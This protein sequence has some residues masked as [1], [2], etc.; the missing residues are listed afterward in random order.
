MPDRDPT[1]IIAEKCTTFVKFLFTNT[2]CGLLSC[3]CG[4]CGWTP[5]PASRPSRPPASQR[6]GRWWWR[7]LRQA[8][9]ASP[10][11]RPARRRSTISASRPPGTDS[12]LPQPIRWGV[13]FLK[14][15]F[16]GFFFV[17]LHLP[18]LRFH[19][20]DG[21][22]DRTQDPSVFFISKSGKPISAEQPVLWILSGNQ[23]RIRPD[24]DP[25]WAFLGPLKQICCSKSINMIKYWTF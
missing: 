22:W 13:F 2:C 9:A 3:R 25:S 7:P 10:P 21:C 20:A 8:A 16:G 14:Y 24:P 11:S 12:S 18:F 5:P 23:L 1:V 4:T 19:C 6:T 15:F 17:L